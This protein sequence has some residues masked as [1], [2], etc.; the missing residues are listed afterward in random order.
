M[1]NKGELLIESLLS[2]LLISIC[3]IP[4]SD[5]IYNSFRY[6]N[7]QNLNINTNINNINL[8][9]YLKSIEHE[10]IIKFIGS[11]DFDNIKEACNFFGVNE[12][13]FL[14]SD[15][16]IRVVIKKSE[17]IEIIKGDEKEIIYLFNIKV[18][19]YEDINISK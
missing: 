1:K 7:R 14:D 6:I 19:D 13:Y 3:L 8:L 9:E 12:N 11:H 4:I 17:E 18:G 5:T 2:L 10:K 15:R 16:S